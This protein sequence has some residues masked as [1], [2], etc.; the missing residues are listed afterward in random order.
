M[1]SQESVKGTIEMAYSQTGGIGAL[2]NTVS[3][4]GPNNTKVEN[5][6]WVDFGRTLR[7]NL[8]GATWLNQAVLRYK[9]EARDGRITHVSSIA[10]KD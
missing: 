6:D 3:I 4:V 10:G 8:F 1:G 5:V 2:I 7:I 9:K